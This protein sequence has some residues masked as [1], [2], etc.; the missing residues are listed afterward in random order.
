MMARSGAWR[1][2]LFRGGGRQGWLVCDWEI[3]RNG[4]CLTVS[5]VGIVLKEVPVGNEL[6]GYKGYQAAEW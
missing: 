1:S 2:W 3:D 5:I 6:L 4:T